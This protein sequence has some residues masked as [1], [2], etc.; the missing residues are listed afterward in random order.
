M[1]FANADDMQSGIVEIADRKLDIKINKFEQDLR[2]IAGL[3]SEL[4]IR[5]P[6]V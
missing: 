1:V 2:R 3:I 6:F 5:V 4:K